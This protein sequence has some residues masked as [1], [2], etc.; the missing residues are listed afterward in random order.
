VGW[1]VS[2]LPSYGVSAQLSANIASLLSVPPSNAGG[3]HGSFVD[4][5]VLML[6]FGPFS[7]VLKSVEELSRFSSTDCV[8]DPPLPPEKRDRPPAFQGWFCPGLS[9][10]EANRVA[11]EG[12]R[13][14][15]RLSAIPNVFLFHWSARHFLPPRVCQLRYDGLAGDGQFWAG[16]WRAETPR[17]AEASCWVLIGVIMEYPQDLRWV[18]GDEETDG[19]SPGEEDSWFGEW[20]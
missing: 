11:V 3:G 19:G 9:D 1:L 14:L 8:F 2:G 18:S 5:L 13:S 4:Y 10:E 7:R 6:R 20:E 17:R 16:E 15:V 12:G